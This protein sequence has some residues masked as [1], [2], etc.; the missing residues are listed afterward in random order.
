MSGI[1]KFTGCALIAISIT[2]HAGLYRWTAYSKA[3]WMGNNS[4]IAWFNEH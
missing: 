2:S 3:C 4:S 1:K